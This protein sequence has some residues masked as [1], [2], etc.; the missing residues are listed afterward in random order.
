MGDRSRLI[1]LGL[2]VGLVLVAVNAAFAAPIH[3][4]GTDTETQYNRPGAP[5]AA[6]IL[7]F[8]DAENGFDDAQPGLVTTSDIAALLGADVNFEVALDTSSF[9]PVTG[10]VLYA[11][12]IGTGAM[13]EITMMSGNTALLAFQVHLLDVQQAA[14]SL[15]PLGKPVGKIVLGDP[16]IDQYGIASNLTVAGGTLNALVGGVG[17]RAVMELLMSSLSP[18]MT[19]ALRDSGYLNLNFTNGVGTDLESATWNITIIP[20]PS[21]AVLLGFSLLG[22]VAAA[23]RK[24][25]R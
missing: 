12:F 14:H 22:I 16:K 7:T 23:R 17:T 15:S 10:N 18:T 1:A 24:V 4:G 11:Q 5:A 6:G 13:P 8:D 21:T 9:D 3:I 20:E 25:P 19:K 2:A